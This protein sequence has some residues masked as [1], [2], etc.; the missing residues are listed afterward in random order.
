MNSGR[1][2]RWILYTVDQFYGK[3]NNFKPIQQA[4]VSS[5][6]KNAINAL[7]EEQTFLKFN[8]EANWSM[9]MDVL[10][11]SKLRGV[12][13]DKEFQA[14]QE[15][16]QTTLPTHLKAFQKYYPAKAV[17]ILTDHEEE[18]NFRITKAETEFDNFSSEA[19]VMKEFGSRNNKEVRGRKSDCSNFKS[20]NQDD[21]ASS[22][23]SANEKALKF[24]ADRDFS[25]T[26][27]VNQLR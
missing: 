22:P 4:E 20:N 21:S 25:T 10:K 18:S 5:R 2:L 14:N 7:F 11:E 19:F 8:D 1:A 17:K 13:L 27:L 9:K 12:E 3:T 26:P 15:N 24:I 23:D 6:Y 16:D